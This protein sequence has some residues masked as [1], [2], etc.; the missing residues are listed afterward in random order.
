MRA[1]VAFTSLPRLAHAAGQ[2]A[3]AWQ[4]L[5]KLLDCLDELA[6]HLVK[7]GGWV[8]GWPGASGNTTDRAEGC[9]LAHRARLAAWRR[10]PACCSPAA[11]AT[12]LDVAQDA[13]GEVDRLHPPAAA[14]ET[15]SAAEGAASA[16]GTLDWCWM[17][18]VWTRALQHPH[19]QA[20]VACM[21]SLLRA[22]GGRWRSPGC[23]ASQLGPNCGS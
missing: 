7:V 12:V 19:Q 11:N 22:C 8:A 1:L 10:S 17:E 3:P 18:V 20:S 21:L 15:A 5:L 13:W 23:W 9:M 6:P 2:L 14:A 16:N 4:P